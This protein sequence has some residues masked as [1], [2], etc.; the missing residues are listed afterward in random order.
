MR[1]IYPL[2][3]FVSIQFWSASAAATELEG[4]ELYQSFCA[5]CHEQTERTR[6]A[7]YPHL[8]DIVA[9]SEP[10][11][12]VDLIDHGQFRRAGETLN[13]DRAY[14]TI[15][16]MPSW[17]WLT[18][19]ELAQLV[20]FLTDRYGGGTVE[21]SAVEVRA[22]R[23]ATSGEALSPSEASAAHHLYLTHCAGCHGASRQGVVGPALSQ[24]P[25]ANLSM[26]TIRATLHYGTLDGM[27]EWGVS[28]QLTARQMTLLARYLQVPPLTGPPVF[29]LQTIKDSWQAPEGPLASRQFKA[30]YIVTLLHD[31]GRALYIDPEQKEVID[32]S[33]IGAAPY[34]LLQDSAIWILTRGGWI[35][36]IDPGT[37]RVRAKVRAGYEATAFALGYAKG[38]THALQYLAATTTSPPGVSFFEADTLKPLQRVEMSEP[39]GPVVGDTD[40]EAVLTRHSGCIYPV[41]DMQLAD[42][43]IEGVPYPRYALA[44]PTTS[45]YLLVGELGELAV[46]DTRTQKILARLDLGME[47]TPGRGSFVMHPDHGQV[48]IV[49]S[50]TSEEIRI[51]GADPQAHPDDAWKILETIAAPDAGSLFVSGHEHSPFVLV[52]SALSRTDPGSVLL[53]DRTDNF[54]KTTVG[55]AEPAQLQGTPRVL[56]PLFSPSGSEVWLTVWNRMDETSALAV[57]DSE[58]A[59]L[60]AVIKDFRLTTPLRS[61]WVSPPP[62]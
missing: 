4:A 23:D 19:Q 37:K 9:H 62:H 44:L 6:D 8:S 24:W 48:F 30:P 55:I 54:S 14:Q 60:K 34:N 7:W 26:E 53:L 18:D 39:I 13:E 16:I 45:Y 42:V 21:L 25:L 27:P 57:L 28:V 1:K 56:Q 38:P 59:Q 22:L 32:Q 47:F 52:D 50:M 29:D 46:F 5:N 12:L 17:S 3:V 33:E 15:P 20:N 2:I 31:G 11:H 10:E 40:L 61:F 49:A 41:V 35:V 51:V 43:C 58:T 36:Q